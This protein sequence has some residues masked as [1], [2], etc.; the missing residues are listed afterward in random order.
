MAM[1][2]WHCRDG[3][4]TTIN[5]LKNH[6]SRIDRFVTLTTMLRPVLAGFQPALTGTW[7]GTTRAANTIEEQT[8]P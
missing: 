4:S 7:Q 5:H 8:R 3:L 6:K 2:I 1:V